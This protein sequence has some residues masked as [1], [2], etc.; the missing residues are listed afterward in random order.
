[1]VASLGPQKL[2]VPEKCGKYLIASASLS[3]TNVLSHAP[4]SGT[5]A[6][7]CRETAGEVYSQGQ[8]I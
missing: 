7:G 8:G 6:L 4:L 3:P 1:M 5:I 2:S